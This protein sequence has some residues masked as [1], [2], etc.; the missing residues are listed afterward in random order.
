[1]KYNIASINYRNKKV[2]EKNSYHHLKKLESKSKKIEGRSREWTPFI[3]KPTRPNR[4]GGGRKTLPPL[5]T[6]GSSSSISSSSPSSSLS[7]TLAEM[8]AAVEIDLNLHLDDNN[9]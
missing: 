1:M 4:P 3:R 8:H 5:L 7:P 2:Q 9:L 6:Q